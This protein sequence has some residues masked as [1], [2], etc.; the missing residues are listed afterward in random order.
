MADDN[1]CGAV[2]DGCSVLFCCYRSSVV[3]SIVNIVK[4]TLPWFFT[5]PFL[6]VLWCLP[7][8]AVVATIRAIF[9]IL[10]L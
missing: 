3:E 5:L 9:W 8:L 6:I 1:Y 4:S 2:S 7:V 10:T